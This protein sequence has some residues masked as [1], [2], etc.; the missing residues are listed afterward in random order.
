MLATTPA[1]HG[2]LFA[3]FLYRSDLFGEKELT[4]FWECHF[5]KCF[6]YVPE[7]NPLN[8]YYSREMGPELK[9]IFF[10]TS[11]KFPRDYLLSTKLKSLKWERNW[12]LE[13]KRM[14]NVDIGFLSLE[15]FTLATTKN[16]SQRIYLGQDIYSDLTYYF[17]LGEF[18]T[19]AWTYPDFLD[20]KKI[21]FLTW[22]RSFLLQSLNG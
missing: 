19:L 14:V 4:E 8:E 2:L 12:A 3:S 18:K 7:F 22:G 11:Q 1:T 15:N 17:H 13:N 20:P 6:S 9:R 10:L 16:Y 21:Q 5:E